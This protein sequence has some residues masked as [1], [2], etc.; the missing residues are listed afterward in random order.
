[1]DLV[2]IEI[3]VG[4]LDMAKIVYKNGLTGSIILG[5]EKSKIFTALPEHY[6]ILNAWPCQEAAGN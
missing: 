3:L 4:C 2:T 1:M 5:E 6:T